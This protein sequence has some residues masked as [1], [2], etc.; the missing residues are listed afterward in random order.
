M[1]VLMMMMLLMMMTRRIGLPTRGSRPVGSVPSADAWAN[2]L[3]SAA[4]E[5]GFRP[6]KQDYLHIFC[7]F[8]FPRLNSTALA[9]AM[10]DSATT[11]AMNTPLERRRIGI[12]SQ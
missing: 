8:H 1:I 11:I 12:A 5:S 3:R 9:A 6:N 7:I 4:A 10:A 2:E